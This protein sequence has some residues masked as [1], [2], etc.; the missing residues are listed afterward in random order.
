MNNAIFDKKISLEYPDDFYE[1]NEGIF[2]AFHRS[3][4]IMVK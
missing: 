1:M 2:K 3:L 4:K